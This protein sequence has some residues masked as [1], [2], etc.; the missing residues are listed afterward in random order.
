[1]KHFPNSKSDNYYTLHYSLDS[2]YNTKALTSSHLLC[3]WRTWGTYSRQCFAQRV[4]QS[5]TILKDAP[6]DLQPLMQIL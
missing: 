3:P 5:F 2:L 6:E 4:A 1:M